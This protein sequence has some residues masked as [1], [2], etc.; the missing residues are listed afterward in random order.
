MTFKLTKRSAPQPRESPNRASVEALVTA[1]NELTGAIGDDV[2]RALRVGELM[3]LGVLKKNTAGELVLANSSFD[4]P[5]GYM[6]RNQ[7]ING[8][9][10]FAQ[11]GTSQAV[12]A[13]TNE[14]Y[15]LD[16]W[17]FAGAGLTGV[18]EVLPLAPGEILGAQ[19]YMRFTV[20]T[21]GALAWMGQ[22]VENVRRL[23]NGKSVAS[24]WM[25]SPSGNKRVGLRLVQNFGT[26]GSPSAAVNVFG[27]VISLTT[28]WQY[29]TAVF[30]T[31]SIVGKTLGTGGNDYLSLIF[32]VSNAA[33][34][35]SMVGQVG[36]FD[37]ALSQLEAG[38]V[39]T[40]FDFRHPALEL[41][42]C[43]RYFEKSY[44]L[45]VAPGTATPQGNELF[46]ITGLSSAT[47]N[48]L[49]TV[50]Y[51]VAKRTQPAITTYSTAT[52]ASGRVRDAINSADVIPT[53]SNIGTHGFVWGAAGSAA[54]TSLSMNMQWTADSEIR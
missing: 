9:F 39:A 46:Q 16:R 6:G 15:L 49:S 54:S 12:A 50:D 17:I 18:C 30:D 47:N 1:V 43:Q 31:P 25:R 5:L 53:V 32:D 22:R 20:T 29:F 10:R 42:L 2:N 41:M 23:S 26:G 24:F 45:D 7:L 35:G 8:D 28:S 19:N 48:F 21:V 4:P 51:A 37:L 14:I 27:R 38:D 40:G 3:Q 11:R 52:G 13:I 36:Q 44:S 34:D 33:Y